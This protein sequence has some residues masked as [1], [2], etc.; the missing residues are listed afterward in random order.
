MYSSPIKYFFAILVG[1]SLD[2]CLY[3]ALL[4]YG[5]SVYVGNVVGFS[6]GLMVNIL[7]IRIFV[8]RDNRFNF[9]LDLFFSILVN[10]LMFLVGTMLLWI[11]VDKININPYWAKLEANGSTFILNYFVRSKFFRRK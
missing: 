9:G 2:F 1:Y 8:F 10:G 5:C 6:F 3:V 7:L 4:N 11:L